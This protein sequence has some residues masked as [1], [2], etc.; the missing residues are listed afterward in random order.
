LC[1]VS[2][3]AGLATTA[4]RNGQRLLED[5]SVANNIQ[6]AEF[7]RVT[8]CTARAMVMLGEAEALQGIFY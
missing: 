2:L 8:L 4:L 1:V 6:G 7:E 5:L 3:H